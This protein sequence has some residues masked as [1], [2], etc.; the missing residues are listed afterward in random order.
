MGCLVV[1]KTSAPQQCGLSTT[2]S[3]AS[4]RGLRGYALDVD[5][6]AGY[7][8]STSVGLFLANCHLFLESLDDPWF[9]GGSL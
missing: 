7:G 3:S 6:L 4:F 9:A 2:S 8:N 1:P 5:G